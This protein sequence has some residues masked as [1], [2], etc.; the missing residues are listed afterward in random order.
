MTQR[1]AAFFSR[2]FSCTLLYGLSHFSSALHLHRA[3]EFEK[4][5]K[6][7]IIWLRVISSFFFFGKR[8]TYR[9]RW[10]VKQL[11][12]RTI[13]TIAAINWGSNTRMVW[14]NYLGY[15]WHTITWNHIFHAISWRFISL[16]FSIFQCQTFFF[17]SKSRR[18]ESSHEIQSRYRLV[19]QRIEHFKFWM[20][21]RTA[22]VTVW[23]VTSIVQ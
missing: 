4:L 8:H 10:P 21:I 6:S 15:C 3:S 12:I 13:T 17:V 14:R 9:M 22:P 20:K 2:I 18:I 7:M 23:T 5:I 11:L 1:E 19:S 16:I